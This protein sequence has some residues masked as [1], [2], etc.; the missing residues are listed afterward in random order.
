MKKSLAL[1]VSV[2]FVVFLVACN[3]TDETPVDDATDVDVEEVD[4]VMEDDA[5]VE[6][7]ADEKVDNEEDSNT[8]PETNE[9]DAT[10]QTA[11]D[12]NGGNGTNSK[13]DGN[14]GSA[15]N[16]WDKPDKI[17]DM[18]HLEIVHL[19]Y[20]IFAAQDK[21]DYAF[22]ESVAA[23]GTTVDKSNNKFSFKNVTYPFEMDFFSKEDLGKLEFRYTHEEDGIVYVGFGAINYEEESSFVVDFQF[24]EESA[25]WKMKSMDINK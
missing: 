3:K 16:G 19:A 5:E 12:D 1:F 10:E 8:E 20:D 25:K 23:E 14:N 24:V 2:L 18:A 13:N 4:D 6:N 17:D 7:D 9:G 22:L 21:K 11:S 15:T